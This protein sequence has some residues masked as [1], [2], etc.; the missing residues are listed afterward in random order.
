MT[1]AASAEGFTARGTTMWS[2]TTFDRTVW[3]V[4]ELPLLHRIRNKAQVLFGGADPILAEV[5]AD[6]G[7]S[8]SRASSLHSRARSALADESHE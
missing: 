4:A 6:G 8:E 3:D 5:D 1:F 2:G 7:T